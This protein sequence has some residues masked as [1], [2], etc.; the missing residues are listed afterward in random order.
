METSCDCKAP[1]CVWDPTDLM[2]IPHLLWATGAFLMWEA[3]LENPDLFVSAEPL[4]C[5]YPCNYLV[6]LGTR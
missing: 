5:L 3:A 1:L 2:S 4:D 6:K